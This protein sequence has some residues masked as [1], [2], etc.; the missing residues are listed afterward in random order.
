LQPFALVGAEC[1]ALP[2]AFLSRLAVLS[3]SRGS[4]LMPRYFPDQNFVP[5]NAVKFIPKMEALAAARPDRFETRVLLHIVLGYVAYLSAVA[6]ALLLSL[7]AVVAAFAS[8]VIWLVGAAFGSFASGIALLQSLHVEFPAPKGIP[9]SREDAPALHDLVEEL[10]AKT[11]APKVA[12]ILMI[13]E[14]N[15]SITSRYVNGLLGK[16]STTLSLGLPLLQLLS[17]AEFKALLHHE[18]AHS[19]GGHG[20]AGIWTARVWESWG[21]LPLIDGDMG[22]A[23][24][25]ILPTIY[26]W[27]M[28]KLAAYYAV[29]SRM[30]EFAAD[31]QAL[32]R[33]AEWKP[34]LMLV[35][36]ALA[37][38]FMGRCFWPGIW[39]D[40]RNLPRTPGAVFSRLPEFAK[41]VLG[42][43]IR[44]WLKAALAEKA[45][46]LDSHPDMQARLKALG[47]N[48]D[49][50]EFAKAI[51]TLG[52]VPQTTAAREY[53]GNSLAKYEKELTEKWAKSCFL[54]WEDG[55]RHFEKVRKQWASIQELEKTGP[56]DAPRR[57]EQALCAWSLEGAAEAEAMLVRARADF[58]ESPEI[59]F[60][61]GRTLLAQDKEEGI[62]FMER[63][64]GLAPTE[65]R[66]QGTVEICNYLNRHNRPDEAKAFFNR[67]ARED[68]QQQKMIHERGNIT[69]YDAVSGHGLD[70]VAIA[71]MGKKLA[72]LEWVTEAYICRKP[73]PL[74]PERPLYLLCL[75]ARK[76]FLIPA[77]RPGMT[78]FDQVAALNCYPAETRFLLMDGAQPT[79]EKKIRKAAG[80]LLFKRK[81]ARW[82]IF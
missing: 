7:L 14:P 35:R 30:H 73:T 56:L 9:V 45:K 23:A 62:P 10:A 63:M 72:T 59:A 48:V 4:G 60:N 37:D 34:D 46:P 38:N 25:L 71:E 41:S 28:P 43:D 74:S 78:A 42:K 82:L 61:L 27:F 58:P 69:P 19:S 51:E 17:P 1:R 16:T 39:K 53:L 66:Y 81:T 33:G 57:L 36:I 49:V 22:F 21:Q 76:N 68:E 79:L 26:K 54:N 75:K 65:I 52:F 64:I 44:E 11:A 5:A 40:T 3:A 67:M 13:P 77:F 55:Y 20:H 12:G 15:A 18:F 70:G 6:L 80:S 47:A 31:Q 29:L 8:R 24:R 32:L 50:E 2:L